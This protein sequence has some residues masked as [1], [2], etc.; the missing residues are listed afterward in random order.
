[1]ELGKF[2][3]IRYKKIFFTVV[4][5]FYTLKVE[6]S[7]NNKTNAFY[8]ARYDPKM[9]TCYCIDNVDSV[10]SLIP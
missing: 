8:R 5:T 4:L 3:E 2:Y 6:A 10:K 9:S 1:M 7:Y